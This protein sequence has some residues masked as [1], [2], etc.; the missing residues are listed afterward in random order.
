MTAGAPAAKRPRR[1]KPLDWLQPAVLTGSLLPVAFLL[2]RAGT[3]RLGANPIATAMNQLGLLTLLLLLATLSCTPLKIAFGLKWPLKL[4][5]TL[6]LLTF[7]TALLH[8]SVYLFLDQVAMLGAVLQDVLKRPFIAV[9]FAAL[10]LMTPLAI[11]STKRALQ[12]MGPKRWQRLHRLVYA[13]G[14]L[15]VIHFLLRVKQDVTEP[16]IYGGV[17]VLLLTTRLVDAVRQ[18]RRRAAREAGLE[19]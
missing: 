12:R 15:G 4:R 10:V 7:F 18:R 17:L 6:G 3:G 8:F 1:S 13:V 5:K 16:L 11:T 2:Y 9:G 19:A 14:V